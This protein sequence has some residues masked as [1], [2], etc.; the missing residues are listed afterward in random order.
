[1]ATIC[2]TDE[3]LLMEIEDQ[4]GQYEPLLELDYLEL[5][6]LDDSRSRA[7]EKTDWSYGVPCPGVRYFFYK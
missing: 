7:P 1:M 3:L 2:I 4:L 5:L 6:E